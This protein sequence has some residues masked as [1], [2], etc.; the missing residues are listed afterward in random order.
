MPTYS[1]GTFLKLQ[2]ERHEQRVGFVQPMNS[3]ATEQCH[4]TPD[5]PNTKAIV[6]KA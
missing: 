2:A 6:G 5:N 3:V 1:A 4:A